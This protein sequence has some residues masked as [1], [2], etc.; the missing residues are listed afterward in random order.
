MGLPR[1]VVKQAGSASVVQLKL[2]VSD[3]DAEILAAT[4]ALC[5]QAAAYASTAAWRRGLVG[6]VQL[7][8]S[9]YRELREQFPSL[10]AQA[11]V[12]AIARVVGAHANRSASRKRAHIFRSNGAVPFDARMLTSNRDAG[13]ISIWT[14]HGRLQLGY[15]G[16]DIDLEAVEQLPPGEC[17][18]ICRNGV[19]LLKVAVAV[20][21][22]VIAEPVAGFLGVDQG[23]AS[24]AVTS[25]GAV[26][27]G[28]VLP[29]T[30]KGNGHVRALRAR[31]HRQRRRLQTKATSSARRVLRRLAGR[32]ARTIADVNHQI[33]KHVVREAEHTGRG[34][35]L[36]DLQGIRG[37][38]RAHRSQRRTLHSWAFAQ[39]IGF[40][41]YKTQ[42]AGVALVLVDPAYTSQT[43]PERDHISRQNRPA[44][45]GRF[46]CQR[47]GLAGHADHIAAINVSIRAVGGWGAVNRPHAT[48]LP[49]ARRDQESKPPV[50]PVVVGISSLSSSTARSGSAAAST[51]WTSFSDGTRPVSSTSRTPSPNLIPVTTNETSVRADPPSGAPATQGC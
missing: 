34:V 37:R 45:G 25:D 47:C 19:W 44:R 29:G 23:V 4:V 7:H 6:Q 9:V 15:L 46:L 30:V 33:S 32:E 18:L 14:P 13:T 3:L 12:R 31:R 50:Q 43:C 39:M 40:V 16:R 10:G 49:S 20:P 11:A 1:S 27:P 48:D 26:L 35:A 28:S 17:D 5:N 38:A 21:V 42:R 8:R 2:L 51:A 22:S 41:R 24:L 36:E